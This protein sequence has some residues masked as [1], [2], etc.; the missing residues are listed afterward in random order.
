MSA[1][2]RRGSGAGIRLP[3]PRVRIFRPRRW[4]LLLAILAGL[5]VAADLFFP[6]G[7][8]PPRRK[9]VIL[10][11]RGESLRQISGEL[12]RVG[13]LRGT[14]GFEVL[15]RVMRLDRH[16]KAGQYE[17]ALGTPV[18]ALLRSL[19][20]GM[21]G[22][23]LV[24]IPEGLTLL[25]V[26]VL[27]SH[28]LGVP[29]S[30]FDSLGHDRA[31]CDSLGIDAPSLEGYLAP[32][33]YEFLPGT[34]PEVAFR[35]MVAKQ[36]EVLRRAAAGR[37]SLPLG[38]SLRQLLILASIV[39]SEARLPSERPRIARV[40]LNRLAR[41]M[42]LQADPTVSFGMG[43][44]PRARLVLRNLRSDSPYNTYLYAGLPPGPICNPGRAA[45]EATLTP[46]PAE[47]SLYFVAR[48]DGSHLFGRTYQEHLVNI[49]RAH[50]YQA[51]AAALAESLHTADSLAAQAAERG[52]QAAGRRPGSPP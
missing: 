20:Q 46:S 51:A 41:E 37:D 13:L 1:W 12:K 49:R 23:N 32:D 27:L 15:A 40:Y 8:F 42:K 5:A 50:E 11:Q 28:H 36:E 22:L 26:G 43:I 2:G 7:P 35:T 31:F 38:L 3:R 24:T 21:S 29:V 45:I 16:I 18:P 25:E 47:P 6:A 34:S 48:G 17:F 19:A 52:S 39:E 44:G 14:L 10:V 33:T 9:E 30:A 4:A